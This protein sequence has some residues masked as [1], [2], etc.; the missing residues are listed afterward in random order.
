MWPVSSFVIPFDQET[1]FCFLLL[2]SVS[3]SFSGAAC[4]RQRSLNYISSSNI[5]TVLFSHLS[6]FRWFWWFSWFQQLQLVYHKKKQKKKKT[7]MTRPWIKID[8]YVRRSPISA[9]HQALNISLVRWIQFRI[10]AVWF[11]FWFSI[12][13]FYF[14]NSFPK[15]LVGQKCNCH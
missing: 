5:L 14:L 8:F 3:T 2:V 7:L 13:H 10:C 12:F 9:R 6:R 11:Y 15:T 4:A 1:Q